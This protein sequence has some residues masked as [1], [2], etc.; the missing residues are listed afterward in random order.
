VRFGVTIHGLALGESHGADVDA[1]GQGA[2]TGP[3]LHQLVPQSRTVVD[4]AFT[5]QFLDPDVQA[6]A[7]TFG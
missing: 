2:L 3:R 6:Y 7:F 5:I 4:H 1:D